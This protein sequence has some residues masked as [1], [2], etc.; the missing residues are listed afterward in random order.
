MKI[1]ICGSND[2]NRL[3]LIKSFI[4]K[5]PMYATPAENIFDDI[6]WPSESTKDLEEL[7]SKLND[8]EKILFA[9]MLLLETQYEKYNDNRYI[10]YNGSSI[11]ILINALALCEEGIVSEDFVERVIYHNK[12]LLRKLDVIY[13]QPN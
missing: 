12:K 3:H 2:E 1:A 13:Y 9:K 4:S 10:I 8:V 5:W 6:Q 7:K 11:D